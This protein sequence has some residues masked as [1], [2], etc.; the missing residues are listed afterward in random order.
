MMSFVPGSILIVS[1][2]SC[3]IPSLL[4]NRIFGYKQMMLK[5]PHPHEN[6][7]LKRQSA[8]RLSLKATAVDSS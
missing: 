6:V 7:L 8:D 4:R 3:L 5:H 1:S 2:L